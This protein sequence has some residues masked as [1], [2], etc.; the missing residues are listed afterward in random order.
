M[1]LA[2]TRDEGYLITYK[3]DSIEVSM[4]VERPSEIEDK[5][6]LML[7]AIQLM[8]SGSLSLSDHSKV[9]LPPISFGQ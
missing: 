1:W 3:D 9:S 8:K 2:T 6:K 5:R 4:L 7:A